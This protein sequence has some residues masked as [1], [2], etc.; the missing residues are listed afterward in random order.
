[1]KWFVVVKVCY[2]PTDRCLQWHVGFIYISESGKQIVV[3]GT[4][5]GLRYR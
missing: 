3:A 2:R 5:A 4:K 1:M